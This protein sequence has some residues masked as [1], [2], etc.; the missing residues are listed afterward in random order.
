MTALE[1]PPALDRLL[2]ALND[3]DLDAMVACFAE[4]Y[5][6]HTPAHP[7][8]GFVGREQ[9]RSNWSQIFA[10]VPDVRGSLTRTAVDGQTVWSEWE[11]TGTRADSTAFLMRGVVIFQ[12]PADTFTAAAFYLEPV[13]DLSGGPDQ[14]VHDLVGHPSS[15][16][17][18][19]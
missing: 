16:K 19:S 11:L 12:V 9:V 8:R 14:A 7:A 10:G 2:H 5:V 3:H 18:P 15:A 13:E 4:D 1:V 17:E 6:N